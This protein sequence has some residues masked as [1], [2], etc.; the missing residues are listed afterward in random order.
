MSAAHAMEAENVVA[1]VDALDRAGVEAW[2]DGGWCVDALLGRVTRVHSDLDLAL[3]AADLE[4]T[5]AAL[6]PLGYRREPPSEGGADWNVILADAS[7][8]R[9]DI[10][11][12]RFDETGAAILGAP[13]QGSAYPAGALTGAGRIASRGVRCVAANSMVRFK[14][15]YPPRPIDIA[16]VRALCAAFD[17]APPAGITP[18]S[19]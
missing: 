15:S 4:V 13:E 7:G 8:R 6:A 19:A 16:D 9:I 14:T 11:A 12:F 2:V 10:H 17:L 18:P 5:C 1:I 3:G